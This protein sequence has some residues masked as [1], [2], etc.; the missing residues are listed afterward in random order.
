MKCRIYICRTHIDEMLTK[1]QIAIEAQQLDQA[2]HDRVQIQPSSVRYP[3]ITIDDA[4]QI[5]NAWVNMKI[6]RGRKVVGHKVGL[7]SKAMQNAM[8][9]NESDFGIL[10]DDMVFSDNSKIIASDFTDPRIEVEI[11]F[12]LAHD[13]EVDDSLTIEKVI[14]QCEY[15]VPS[16]ELIAARSY[17]VDPHTG[18]TRKVMDTISDNAANA[19][20]IIGSTSIPKEADLSWISAVLRKNGEIE[21]SGVAGAVLNHPANGVIWLARKYASIG[22]KLKAGQIVLAGSF[23]RP[24]KVAAGD[25]IVADF[26]QF[27]QVSCQFI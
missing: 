3:A 7:T 9:I 12:K 16:M 11:A 4:Y 23:T 21:E 14:N 24:V 27:G 22:R 1:D 5:Q 19:G 17:R 8:N 13:L 18:Y 26:N 10:L 6:K 15:I 25:M 20:I 2:E